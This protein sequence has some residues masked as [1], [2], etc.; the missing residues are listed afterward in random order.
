MIGTQGAGF[1]RCPATRDHGPPVKNANVVAACNTQSLTNHHEGTYIHMTKRDGA[2]DE[3]Y[4]MLVIGSGLGG[5]VA[6]LQLTKKKNRTRLLAVGGGRPTDTSQK[7]A[8]IS[9]DSRGHHWGSKAHGVSFGC[10]KSW[11]TPELVSSAAPVYC[12]GCGNLGRQPTATA[13]RRRTPNRCRVRHAHC[14]LE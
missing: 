6:A 5:R 13:R 7:Q 11:S 1:A 12:S 4:D 9:S 2:H 8:G 10:P 3:D 14:T